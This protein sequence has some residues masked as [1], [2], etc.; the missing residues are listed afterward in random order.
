MSDA[1]TTGLSVVTDELA[2]MYYEHQYDRMGKLEEQT[3]AVTNVVLATSILAITFGF[4]GSV[5]SGVVQAIAL[6]FVTIVANLFA[7]GYIRNSQMFIALHQ[8]R[9][10]RVLELYAPAMF[11]LN[12]EL[13]WPR[14]DAWRGRRRYHILLHM[15]FCFAAL[16]PVVIFLVS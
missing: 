7:I 2:R 13:P 14:A 11:N 3:L 6:P 4:Q 16:V 12:S 1:P 15:A 10:M 5:S 9:A 8:R